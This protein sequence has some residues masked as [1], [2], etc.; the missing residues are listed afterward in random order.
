MNEFLKRLTDEY[1]D[2]LL[3]E[4]D[5]SARDYDCYDFGLPIHNSQIDNFRLIVREW[6]HKNNSTKDKTTSATIFVS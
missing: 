2:E 1:V 6:A 4:L 5:E 3:F